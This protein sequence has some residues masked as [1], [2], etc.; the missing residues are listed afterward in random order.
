MFYPY[1]SGASAPDYYPDSTGVFYGVGLANV[2]G[3]YALAVMEGVAFGIRILL[4]AMKA[5]GSINTLVLF[6]G[7]ANSTLWCQIIADVTGMTVK[8]PSTTE[9]AGAGA[10][11]LAAR[12]VGEKPAPLKIASIY[13]PSAHAKDYD[14][15]YE[16]Y[17]AIEKKLWQTGGVT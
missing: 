5:Y 7:G 3:D 11:I 2:R 10:A 16:R 12:A 8:I 14:E 6:G 9:A 1:L 4:E 15:K 17:R 13:A